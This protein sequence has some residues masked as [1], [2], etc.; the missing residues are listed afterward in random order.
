[1]RKSLSEVAMENGCSDE[2][3]RLRDGY[4]RLHDE[5]EKARLQN[6]ELS[7]DIE[8]AKSGAISLNI[9][10]FDLDV[11][12]TT[13]GHRTND[14]EKT[15]CDWQAFGLCLRLSYLVQSNGLYLRMKGRRVDSG[16]GHGFTASVWISLLDVNKNEIHSSG[17]VAGMLEFV[18]G[19]V[20]AKKAMEAMNS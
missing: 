8:K 5:L 14:S 1:M 9:D 20:A 2:Y 12:Q 11:I 4:Y 16:N 6:R 3:Y 15:V 7:L 17:T 10:H 18:S 19:Y 13:E